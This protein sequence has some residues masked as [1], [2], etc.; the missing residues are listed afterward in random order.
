MSAAAILDVRRLEAAYA[1]GQVLFGVSFDIAAG[2]VVTLL[3]RNGMGKTTTIAAIMGIV[4]PRAGA[5]VFAG[6]ETAGWPASASPGAASAWC[7]K[8]ARFFPT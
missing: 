3:G 7:P 5:V 6:T 4:R 2:E 1:D 8:V